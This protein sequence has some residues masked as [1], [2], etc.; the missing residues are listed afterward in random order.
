MLIALSPAQE[1]FLSF[2]LEGAFRVHL[3]HC[4]ANKRRDGGVRVP[5]LP[6]VA[7]LG[8]DNV[9][10]LCFDPHVQLLK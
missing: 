7:R 3:P 6:A 2:R 10:R 8:V 5:L 1:R 9:S 4:W